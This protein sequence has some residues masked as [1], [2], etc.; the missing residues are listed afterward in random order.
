MNRRSFLKFLSSATIG[1]T[2]AYSFPEIIVPKNIKLI[3]EVEDTKNLASSGV[4]TWRKLEEAFNRMKENMYKEPDIIIVNKRFCNYIK[5]RSPAL[6][7][8]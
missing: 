2:V 5:T 3:K 7:G 4:L 6:L 8:L 1:A